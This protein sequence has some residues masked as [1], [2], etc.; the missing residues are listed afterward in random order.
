[1]SRYKPYPSYKQSDLDWFISP[2][3]HWELSVLSNL[4]SFRAGKAHEPFINEHGEYI[5]VNSRFVST[6]GQTKKHCS[7]NLTPAKRND[8][9][10]VMSDLP[11][12]RA[13]AK[14]Y[15]VEQDNIYAV[16]QRVCALSPERIEPR[17]LFFLM[18]RNPW[19]LSHDDGINQTHL[20]NSCFT[21]FRT[22]LP[23]PLEQIEIAEHLDRETTRID[24]LIAKKTR[25]IELLREKRQTLITHAVT[26][27]L[28]PN[29][30]MK[31][32]E[33]TWL[34]KV[35]EHWAIQ[36]LKQLAR[37]DGGAGFPDDEQGNK[38][39]PIPFFKV[40]DLANGLTTAE[41]HITPEV[42]EK[43]RAKIFA[44]G[45]IAF[46]KVGA[47]L[48]LNRRVLMPIPG[49]AD[50]NMMVA[51]PLNVSGEWLFSVLSC[52][53]MAWLVNPGAVPSVNQEQVGNI[54]IP[55]PPVR[56]Q[57]A[58]VSTLRSETTRIDEIILKT[59]FSIELLKERRSAII[60]AAVTG[61]IDLRY[62]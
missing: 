19:L 33:V 62:Q 34:G 24:A 13:L 54:K 2:P 31:D 25:F 1:M 53:D 3:S 40:A 14:A 30:K 52:Y 58:I 48:L 23:T 39:A 42:A 12:G 55:V 41:N 57:A 44:A 8:T 9:L 35:P 38:D 59:E 50:N 29:V 37:L 27:G 45:T 61:Q 56:E 15:Y 7:K 49:C 17:F 6:S 51:I 22:Y 11:N 21:K 28:D 46:A 16:N 20:P 36:P 60:T 5:C 32:S 18:D 26:K 10:L 47:A 43:L 4:V